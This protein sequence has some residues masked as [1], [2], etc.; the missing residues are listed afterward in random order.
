MKAQKGYA[1]ATALPRA[2][3]RSGERL[4]ARLWKQVK[5]WN[6]LANQRRLLASMPDA[7]LKDLGLSRADLE[8]E[9]ERPFWD[10]PLSR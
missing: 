1:I 10:D 7:T 9:V 3:L 6:E 2:K 5:R 4:L 8:Q